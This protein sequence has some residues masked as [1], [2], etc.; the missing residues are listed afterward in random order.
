MRVSTAHG[1]ENLI[2]FLEDMPEKFEREKITLHFERIDMSGM[3]LLTARMCK[4]R[5][6]LTFKK[7][8][9]GLEPMPSTSPK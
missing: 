6:N 8:S 1:L 2:I 9:I 4:V 5:P 3:E 7:M